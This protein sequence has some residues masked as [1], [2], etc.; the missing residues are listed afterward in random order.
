MTRFDPRFSAELRAAFA[1]PADRMRTMMAS[2]QAEME[3]GLR[4]A[5]S[6]LRM[7]PAYVDNPTGREKGS[8]LALDIGGTNFRVLRVDLPGDGRPPRVDSRKFRLAPAHIHGDARLLF[9]TIARAVGSFLA[10]RGGGAHPLGF[11]FSF[12]IRQLTIN[13]GKLIDWSKGWSAAGVE[14]RDVVALLNAAFSREG[15]SGVR[16]VS[17][18]NDTTGT[19]VAR[20]YL[21]RECDAGYILGTGTNLCYREKTAAIRKPLGAYDGEFMIINT[22]SGNFNIDLPRNAVD[23]RLDAESENPGDHWEEKMVSGKYLGEIVRLVAAGLVRDGRLFGGR[24]PRILSRREGFESAFVGEIAADRS[25]DASAT[26][27]LLRRIGVPRAA[28]SDAAALR[29]IAAIV[30]ERAGRIAAAV[31]AAAVTKNDPGLKRRHVVA[32]DGS[33]FENHRRIRETMAATLAELFGRRAGRIAPELTHDGSGLG[34]AVIAA[35]AVSRRAA[36]C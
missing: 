32:V 25:P 26:R 34:A 36:G 6:S 27:A 5:R 29:E 9:G 10:G 18:N 12:P 31:L 16:A 8:F 24:L 3:K 7:L 4:G 2:F 14:G 20:A 23:A 1:F 35:V 13:R 15:V 19:Q 33:V 22:E 11:T 30:S 21:A 17:L 28:A